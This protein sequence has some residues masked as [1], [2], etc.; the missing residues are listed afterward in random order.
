MLKGTLLLVDNERDF[1]KTRAELLEKEGY[2]VLTASTPSEVKQR[3]TGNRIDL[4]I[5]DVRLENDHDENDMSGL[6]LAKEIPSWIPKIILTNYPTVNLVREA[7]HD[8]GAVDFITKE[9]EQPE[10]F[11]AIHKALRRN[12][13]VVHGHE[14]EVLQTI[15]TFLQKM[16]LRP[17]ILRDLPSGGQALIDKLEAAANVAFAVVLFT[18]DDVGGLQSSE[19]PTP[20]ARENVIFELGYFLGKLGKQKVC[21]LHKAN[22]SI[23]SDYQGMPC[24]SIDLADSTSWQLSLAREMKAVGLSIDFAKLA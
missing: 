16:D 18:P 5:T 6:I 11:E 21:I 4:F 20:R 17:I 23:S 3:L 12:V 22:T 14:N 1:L 9:A 24:V 19:S 7:F 8:I 13:F 15:I 10:L 2:R